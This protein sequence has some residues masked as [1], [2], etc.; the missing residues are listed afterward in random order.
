VESI[1]DVNYVMFSSGVTILSPLNRTY[2]SRFLKLDITYGAGLGL[3]HSLNYSI[4]GKHEGAIPLVAKYPDELHVVNQATGNVVL[5][6]LSDG[7]HNLT[8]HVLCG[9]YNF[10]GV[11]PPGAPFQPTYPGSSDYEAYWENTVYFTIA[12]GQENVIPEFSAWTTTLITVVVLVATLFVY[13]RKLHK[14]VK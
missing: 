2:D 3:S 10:H 11:N 7:A 13:K 4:D 9:L 12:T 8:V 1:S 5:P 6:E 14:T